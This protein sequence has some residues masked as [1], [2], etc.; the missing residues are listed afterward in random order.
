MD[1][2]YRT[3]GLII[4][5]HR[6]IHIQNPPSR[7]LDL[8]L[9]LMQIIGFFRIILRLYHHQTDQPADQTC[10][11]RDTTQKNHQRLFLMKRFIFTHKETP[12]K[13]SI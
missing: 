7:R 10:E 9:S 13:L 3:D 12:Q 6:S 2:R 5:Q 1:D 11:H 8:T 4:R